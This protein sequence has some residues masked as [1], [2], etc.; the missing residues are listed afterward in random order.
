MLDRFRRPAQHTD[1]LRQLIA[2]PT[3]RVQPP[4]TGVTTASGPPAQRGAPNADLLVAQQQGRKQPGGSR[5]GSADFREMLNPVSVVA[6]SKMLPSS[7][8]PL[9]HHRDSTLTKHSQALDGHLTLDQ[10]HLITDLFRP[11]FISRGYFDDLFQG[12]KDLRTI[13]G[14]ASGIDY[15]LL[16][17]LGYSFPKGSEVDAALVSCDLTLSCKLINRAGES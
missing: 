2:D 17:K 3:G 6:A 14:S 10:V 9:L 4:T 13:A 12:D 5:Q 11:A 8:R 1:A 7:Y 16:G 15:L